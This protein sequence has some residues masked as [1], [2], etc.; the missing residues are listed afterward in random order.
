MK[1][2]LILLLGACAAASTPAD[3]P[4]L[5][6][7]Q[8]GVYTTPWSM[9]RVFPGD[10][11]HVGAD[12][13]DFG[14]WGGVASVATSF[15][16]SGKVGVAN[17]AGTTLITLNAGSG[18]GP[19]DVRF[20]DLDK[21]GV[22]DLVVANSGNSRVVVIYGG[23]TTAVTIT[24][25][26]GHARWIQVGCGDFNGDGIPDIVGGSYAG[27]A[28]APAVIAVLYGTGSRLGTSWTFEQ[29]TYAGWAMSVIPVDLDGDGDLDLVVTDRAGYKLPGDTLPRYDLAGV[30]WAEHVTSVP[31]GW[32]NHTLLGAPYS[33]DQMFGLVVD[34]DKDG[35]LD[36]LAT[37]SH[38]SQPNYVDI[39][40]GPSWTHTT[41]TDSASLDGHAQGLI[42]A[43]VNKDGTN[44][45]V[46][47][48][49]ESNT[50]CDSTHSGVW[51]LNG[52]AS[53]ERE[54]L[55]GGDGTKFDNV[56]V[57]ANGDVW[58]SEQL[59]NYGIVKYTNPF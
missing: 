55:S 12:G 34:Y 57:D 22:Q 40:V 25:S 47:S 43:D 54:E 52:A 30:R 53:W 29:V 48:A 59:D 13:V 50:C 16:Q 20:C 42:V 18:S 14:T 33:G 21:D 28:S 8:Q 3:S 24:A 46:V 58:D 27:T 23:T 1:S 6:T 11:T 19:E 44:D 9:T 7:V 37:R 51:W 32:V 39:W 4:H 26:Q 41:L 31:A 36:I 10:S 49:W 56:V 38:T 15:E 5:E 2:L 45:I 35:V 17:L